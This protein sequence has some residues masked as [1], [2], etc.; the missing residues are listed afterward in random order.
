MNPVTT[1]MT[2]RNTE[3][4]AHWSIIGCGR[5]AGDES[6]PAVHPHPECVNKSVFG[7]VGEMYGRILEPQDGRLMLTSH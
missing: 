6:V 3:G 1:L 2:P 5:G 4:G 7:E